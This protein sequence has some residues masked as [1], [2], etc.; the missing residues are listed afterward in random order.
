MKVDLHFHLEEGPYSL[1]WLSRTLQ[2]LASTDSD[3]GNGK[4]MHASLGNAE[5]LT[6]HL[7]KR[8]RNGCFSEEWLD[9]YLTVG[10]SRGIGLFGVVDHLYRFREC[11]SYYEKHMLLDDSEI[12]RLQEAWLNHVCVASLE[13]YVEFVVKA[14][15]TRPDLLL[16]VEADFF[17]GGEEELG[18]LLR[19]YDWDH[20]IGSVHFIDGW[21]FDNPDTQSRFAKLEPLET[22][23]RYYGLMRQACEF[24]LFD[25]LAHP[26]NLKVFGFRPADERELLPFYRQLAEEMILNRVATE[27]NTGLAY[28]FPVAEACPSPLL[29]SVLAEH[30]VPIALSSDAHFPDDIGML[31]DEARASA[32]R[33]GYKELTVFE[34]RQMRRIPIGKTEAD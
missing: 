33:A 34:G 10:R 13:E 1:R 23:G 29:L 14:K 31:L 11:R 2:A 24:G 19:G 26:D 4:A 16:G 18:S 7:S 15:K 32:I 22:Y 27:I 28:R 5:E 12:G 25:I 3:I 21:G 6:E 30:G 8:M 20:V 17:E 9:R